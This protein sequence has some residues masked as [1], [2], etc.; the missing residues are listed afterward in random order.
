MTK[1]V[2]FITRNDFPQPAIQL[3]GKYFT[4]KCWQGEKNIPRETFLECVKGAF[5]IMCSH[6]VHVDGEVADVAGESLKVV[7][8]FSVGY[9]H[10]QVDELRKRGIRMG[11]T[12]GVLTEATAETA[13]TLLLATARRLNECYT[14]V[15]NNQWTA[16]SWHPFYL[17][18][19]GLEGATVGV[20]GLGRIG[21]SVAKK[22]VPFNIKR[23]LY[24]SRSEKPEGAALGGE[25]KSVD[26]I[27]KES[28]FIV[29]TVAL[30]AETRHIINKER[31]NSM[32][33]N[34]IIVNIGRGGLIDQRALTEALLNKK[35]G[36][37]GLDVTD[38]E[39]IE[40]NDPL[41]TMDNVVISPH[42]GS[43]T[44]VSRNAMGDLAARNII[45][46][47]TV[48]CWPEEKPIS[49]DALK[50]NIKG[51]FGLVCLPFTSPIDKA[52]VEASGGSL[53]VVSTFSVG[54]DHL[55]VA[56]LRESG[57]RIGYTPGVLTEAVAEFA[58][59]LLLATSRRF[60]ESYKIIHNNEWK[61]ESWTPMFLCGPSLDGS[62]VGILGC[63]RIGLSIAKKL[64]PFNIKRFLYA[65]I[66]RVSE[67]DA[68]GGELKSID[69]VLR[70][71][72]FVIITLSQ[73][74]ET[75]G[76]IN[77]ERLN[78]MKPN[79]ILI[80]A[81]RGTLID[82]DAL[83]EALQNKK[84]AGAG[85]DVTV[86]EPLNPDHPLLKMDNVVITPH[87]ASATFSTRSNMAELTAK[88]IIAVLEN[89]D[90]PAELK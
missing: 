32:K 29:L 19:Q 89:T 80:N 42:I 47:F 77:K 51:A 41:T 15:R 52:I 7:S 76:I 87:I 83:T 9:D 6:H 84:I 35:I 61:P 82:Q 44:F 23:L 33:P 31:I 17:A 20:I 85:L 48:K 43:S 69:D 90:M 79:A 72:D 68:I 39:P 13:V 46:V 2:V 57:V 3:L 38:P 66:N 1:P 81:A 8:C 25:L 4:L 53:K 65:N 34:A 59:A 24:Y 16:D 58:V 54:T 55:N 37:A 71:S 14:I 26:E 67:A 78:M 56:E 49:I 30:N 63:G 36:G 10:L 21:L 74:K 27:V 70:E 62:S 60:N 75:I 12:P 40:P 50:K 88:N 45:A 86:P 28:D 22:L 5:A 64:K 73:T 18:G 11:Y